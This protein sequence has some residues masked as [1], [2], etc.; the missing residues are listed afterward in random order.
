LAAT[1]FL[2]EG[3]SMTEA[4]QALIDI[5]I[6]MAQEL[7][8]VVE[9]AIAASGDPDSLGATQE[10]MEDWELA[11]KACGFSE[12]EFI[13]YLIRLQATGGAALRHLPV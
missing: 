7:Q 4:E 10:L 8:E 5:A 1:I 3:Q 2:F 11:Y 12:E 13:F 9:D 6:L